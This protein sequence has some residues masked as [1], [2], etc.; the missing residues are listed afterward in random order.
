[1]ALYAKWNSGV[2]QKYLS[3]WQQGN[4]RFESDQSHFTVRGTVMKYQYTLVIGDKSGDGHERSDTFTFDCT[5]EDT[6][7]HKAYFEAVKKSKIGLHGERRTPK[8]KFD[9]ILREMGEGTITDVQMAALTK[10]GVCFDRLQNVEGD[11]NDE[12]DVCPEGVVEIFLE[13]VRSQL[14]G[15]EYKIVRPKCINDHKDFSHD[16]GYGC[17]RV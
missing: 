9:S 11:N 16:F 14:P 4:C 3:P 13:M 1:M 10:I 8:L 15:F 17:Y 6:E 12:Y 2:P 5:H 7:I